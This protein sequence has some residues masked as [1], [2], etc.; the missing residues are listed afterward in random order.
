MFDVAYTFSMHEHRE[1]LC[2]N[3]CFRYSVK[4]IQ[5]TST[6]VTEIHVDIQTDLLRILCHMN[7]ADMKKVKHSRHCELVYAQL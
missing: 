5:N 6:S 4:R 2:C 3:V 1:R 7:H